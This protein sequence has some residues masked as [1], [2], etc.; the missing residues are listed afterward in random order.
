MKAGVQPAVACSNACGTEGRAGNSGERGGTLEWAVGGGEDL[1][2]NKKKPAYLTIEGPSKQC[3]V[4]P[5]LSHGRI[6]TG[7]GEKEKK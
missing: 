7:R 4:H 2:R 1:S 3:S 6:T 5:S